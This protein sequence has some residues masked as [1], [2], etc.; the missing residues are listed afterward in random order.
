MT[1]HFISRH[2]ATAEQKALAAKAGF[3]INNAGDVDAFHEE[4][5]NDLIFELRDRE[6]FNGETLVVSVVHPALVAHFLQVLGCRDYC[7]FREL[8]ICLFKNENRA[9]VGEKPDFHT[10]EM[11]VYKYTRSRSMEDGVYVPYNREEYKL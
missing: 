5:V 11:I 4:K 9:A 7:F 8:A 3:T 1:L 6:D 10:T 2:E